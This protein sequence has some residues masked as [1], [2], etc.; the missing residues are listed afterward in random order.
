MKVK[1]ISDIHSETGCIGTNKIVSKR[2][3]ISKRK[4]YD[5]QNEFGQLYVTD[6]LGEQRY[7]GDSKDD[8]YFK[9]FNFIIVEK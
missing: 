1:P 7:I 6:E 5:V 3:V 8:S 9:S 2:L 4:A